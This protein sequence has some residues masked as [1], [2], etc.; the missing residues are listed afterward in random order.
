MENIIEKTMIMM[1]DDS[2]SSKEIKI[3]NELFSEVPEELIETV[4]KIIFLYF[5]K[6][7]SQG[8]ELKKYL[9]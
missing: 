7:F 4:N 8:I 6:G 9:E 5:K 1:L 3:L 2:F